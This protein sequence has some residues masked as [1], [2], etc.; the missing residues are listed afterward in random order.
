[1][2]GWIP[3]FAGMTLRY[4]HSREWGVWSVWMVFLFVEFPRPRELWIPAFAG[5]TEYGVTDD[6]VDSCLRGND[7]EIALCG[8]GVSGQSGWC[9][10]S[11]NS[12]VRG[13][14]GF[15]PAREMTDDGVD[16]C[17]RGNDGDVDSCL[18][19][20]VREWGVWS[21]WMVFLFVEFPRSRELWIPA[22]AGMTEYGVT[23]DGVDSC[24]RG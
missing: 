12:R 14:C 23:D 2:T 8:N 11:L 15:P 16:S 17:L 13:N 6:G 18:R 21:V 19:G 7:V 5:M 9:F 1:M 3:A 24:L 20:N 10:F 4:P 22:F